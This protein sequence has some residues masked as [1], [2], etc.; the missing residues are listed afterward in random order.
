MNTVM[1]MDEAHESMRQMRQVFDVVRLLEAETVQKINE[2]KKHPEGVDPCFA[3]WRKSHPCENCV[4]FKALEAKSKKVK[5][6]F[7]DSVLYQ[8]VAKYVEIDGKAYVMEM[9]N[10]LDDD[11]MLD[12]EGR[13]RLF[14][15]LSGYDDELYIDALTGISNRRYFEDQIRKMKASAGV[16][17]IDLDDFKIYNDTFGHRVGDV[18]LKTAAKVIR[19]GIR[20]SDIIIRYGGDEFLL[21]MPDISAEVFAEKLKQIRKNISEAKVPGYSQIHLTVSIGGTLSSGDTVEDAIIRADQYMYQAKL[22]KNMVVTPDVVSD[23]NLE[24]H[25]SSRFRQKILIIDDSEFNRAILAEVLGG[26]FDILEAENGKEGLEVLEQYERD[27]SLVLLDIIMPVMDGFEVLGEMVNRNWIDDI[28]VIMISSEDSENIICRAYEMGVSDYINRPFDTQVVYRR[29]YNT[30]KLYAKQRRMIQLVTDQVYEKQ[31]NSQIMIGILSQ[32][33][34]YRNGESGQH[35]LRINLITD[36]LLDELARKTDRYNL[37]WSR[38][39]V[40]IT[41]SALHDIGK[42]GIS[43]TIL[44][45]PESLTAE[46]QQIIR[47]HTLIGAALLKNLELY[48]NEELV[49]TAYEICRWHHERYDGNGYPDG[50][51]GEEI[52]IAAQVVSLADAYDILASKRAYKE[53]IPHREAIKKILEGESGIFNPVLLECLVNAQGRIQRELGS[54]IIS[55]MKFDCCPRISNFV[56]K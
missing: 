22:R 42:I 37:S 16:A 36:I 5:M 49:K 11:V 15:K 33:M 44:N 46:E 50:L 34:G 2:N 32:I 39:S 12:S 17:M 9:I 30:I 43:G 20:K 31:K 18:V 21:V 28:P 29:V 19:E 52:P 8:V 13:D 35:I 51:K 38:R 40:I 45:K 3:F 1:T 14:R 24:E 41:A 25:E 53:A 55:D 48:Q 54:Q 27:I 23:G 10:C 4:S 7:I 26:E 47:A 56:E 6:E